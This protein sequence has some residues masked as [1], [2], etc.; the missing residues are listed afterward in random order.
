V[1]G[2]SGDRRDP[3]PLIHTDATDPEKINPLP[4]MNTDKTDLEVLNPY[5][6]SNAR[7]PNDA[8]SPRFLIAN[9]RVNSVQD[10]SFS[11]S[12]RLCVSAS[13]PLRLCGEF[14]LLAFNHHDKN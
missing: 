9:V 13:A 2:T 11:A 14:W 12:P 8:A 5:Y 3:L 6:F 10:G 1:I 4:R 7:K